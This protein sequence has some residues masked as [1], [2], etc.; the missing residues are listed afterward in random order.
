MI[1]VRFGRKILPR[2]R[3]YFTLWACF[4]NIGRYPVRLLPEEAGREPGFE[5]MAGKRGN[6]EMG[7]TWRWMYEIYS[8]VTAF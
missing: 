1:Q 6:G 3:F 4:R 8:G 7:K 5:H 2:R